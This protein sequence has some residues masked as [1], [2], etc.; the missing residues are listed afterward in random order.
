MGIINKGFKRMA[1]LLNPVSFAKSLSDAAYNATADNAEF[2]EQ[3]VKKAVDGAKIGP[4]NRPLTVMIKGANHPLIDSEKMRDAIKGEVISWRKAIVHIP[5]SSPSYDIA[6]IV[7]EGRSIPVTEAMRSMFK[8][9]YF[10]SEGRMSASNL[11]GRAAELWDRSRG[12][13]YPLSES[14][15]LIRIPPRPFIQPTVNRSD[16]VARVRARYVQA[17]GLAWKNHAEMAKS[18]D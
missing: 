15:F 16:V 3:E 2:L 9:L 1:K 11:T 5:E 7:S 6:K 14:T 18:E 4:W 10:V 17:V 13:W 8:L 12:P